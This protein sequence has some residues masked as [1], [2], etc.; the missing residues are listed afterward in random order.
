MSLHSLNHLYFMPAAENI[1]K[2][3]SS[4]IEANTFFLACNDLKTNTIFKVLNKVEILVKE[5]EIPFQ[6]SYCSKVIDDCA[7]PTVIQNT[8][9]DSKTKDLAFTKAK[10]DSSFVGI[11][12]TLR[13]GDLFGTLC[14]MDRN[15]TFTEKDLQLIVSISQFLGYLIDLERDLYYDSLTGLYTRKYVN[16]FFEAFEPSTDRYPSIFLINLDRFRNVNTSEE[17][18]DFLISTIAKRI[19]AC[20]GEDGMAVRLHGDE[21]VVVHFHSKTDEQ[22]GEIAEK[23]LNLISE[24]IMTNFQ[25]FHLTASIGISVYGQE[26]YQSI[27]KLIKLAGFAKDSI[28][29]TGSKRYM[30]CT[31]EIILKKERAVW[32]ESNLLQELS[33]N[34]FEMYY[35]PQYQIG[36]GRLTGFEALI[37][38]KSEKYGYIS[39][40]EFI[41]IA[42]TTGQI[43]PLGNWI[44]KM[45][46]EQLSVWNKK[47]GLRISVAIN[48]SPSQF[49]H[50]GHLVD[51]LDNILNDFGILPS[52]IHFEITETSLIPMTEILVPV[53]AKIRSKGIKIALDDFGTGYSSVL[54]L[55]NLPIDIIKIDQVFVRELTTN[56]TDNKIIQAIVDLAK[57]LHLEIVA[58]GVESQEILQLLCNIGCDTA[59]GYLLGK[60]MTSDLASN[61]LQRKALK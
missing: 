54:Y 1:L 6:E 13:N 33:E 7:F 40:A 44:F 42:E 58:E 8:M 49:N 5:G 52:Q 3:L 55:R 4:L 38:W 31:P 19:K 15:Y 39:P 60:P 59:Q 57:A 26:Q 34:K 23:L 47:Y 35:Q 29:G 17:I 9:L 10:G 43:I 48:I 56:S 18:G 16:M 30:I 50:Y 37:R 11:P 24:P 53:L 36:S 22:R 12:I 61:L 2:H 21:F 45:V 25:A 20:S 28:K 51:Q 27:D 32:I 41:P 14:A 46:C